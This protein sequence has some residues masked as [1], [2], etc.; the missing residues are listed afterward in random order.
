MHFKLEISRLVTAS[1]I[2]HKYNLKVLF[3]PWKMGADKET[4]IKYMIEA[5]KSAEI[6]RKKGVDIIF[7][8]G[9]EYTLFSKGVYPGETLN[10][11]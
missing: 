11:R 3:N 10:D 5:S 1:D 2:A 6:L 8:A 7:V 9:C 4:T